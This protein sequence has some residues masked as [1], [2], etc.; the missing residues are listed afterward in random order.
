[1]PLLYL[2]SKAD[3][4][5]PLSRFQMKLLDEQGIFDLI[6]SMN[7]VVDERHKLDDADLM[8]L[9]GG[10]FH[11]LKSQLAAAASVATGASRR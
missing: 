9:F 5:L 11:Q 6:K 3:V 1:V 7:S 4:G 2:L 10:M 8:K